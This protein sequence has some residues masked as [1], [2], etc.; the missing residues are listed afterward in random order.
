[1]PETELGRVADIV[2]S[3]LDDARRRTKM[4]A[5]M[6]RVARPEA[7]AVIAEELIALARG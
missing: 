2:R 5:A 6:L 1:V 7:A 3:L 4:S